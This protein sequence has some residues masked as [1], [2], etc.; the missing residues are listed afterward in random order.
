MNVLEPKNVAEKEKTVAKTS[1]KHGNSN[2]IFSWKRIPFPLCKHTLFV[3]T[4]NDV[5]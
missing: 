5:V 2:A 4:D 3:E 1:L